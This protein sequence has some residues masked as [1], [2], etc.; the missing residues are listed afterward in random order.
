MQNGNWLLKKCLGLLVCLKA[1]KVQ[2]GHVSIYG[3]E[4]VLLFIT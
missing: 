2:F 3:L 4:L 1:F